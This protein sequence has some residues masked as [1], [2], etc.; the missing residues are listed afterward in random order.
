MAQDQAER[1]RATGPA[2]QSSPAAS[3]A[4]TGSHGL[5]DGDGFGASQPAA[6]PEEPGGR[7][8]KRQQGPQRSRFVAAGQGAIRVALPAE[9][10]EQPQVAI[11]AP[12]SKRRLR[13]LGIDGMKAKRW[14]DVAGLKL[15]LVA[16]GL[17]AAMVAAALALVWFKVAGLI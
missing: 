1:I 3:A 7:A 12:E 5:G 9:S 11:I 8:G 15:H 6:D 2:C 13:D 10:H 16:F 14:Q 17:A 4:V